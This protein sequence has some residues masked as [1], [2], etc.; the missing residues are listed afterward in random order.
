LALIQR[1]ELNEYAGIFNL[2]M[3][4]GS[5]TRNHRAITGYVLIKL[6]LPK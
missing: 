2:T 5:N 4:T 1:L 6:D 3:I